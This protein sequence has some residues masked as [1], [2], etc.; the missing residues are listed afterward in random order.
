MSKKKRC[1]SSFI[2]YTDDF[3][4]LCHWLLDNLDT[5]EHF[6]ITANRDYDVSTRLLKGKRD[7]G[8][9]NFSI[10]YSVKRALAAQLH[11]QIQQFISECPRF[12]S[13]GTFFS[14]EKRCCVFH[15]MAD[16]IPG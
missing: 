14:I 4:A 16:T 1:I 6:D 10:S 9:V 7:K 5:Q 3:P 11:Q 15:A 2:G 8:L 13:F 12:A